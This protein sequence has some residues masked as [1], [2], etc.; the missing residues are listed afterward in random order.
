MSDFRS[1]ELK[2]NR[3]GD[4]RFV[5]RSVAEFAETTDIAALTHDGVPSLGLITTG[6]HYFDWH[7]TEAD[8]LDKVDP[9]DFRKCIAAL[10]VM[11][12]AL[13]DM[14]SRLAGTK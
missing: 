13:A 11:S 14:P 8:T 10:A 5:C 12:Y 7:H 1:Q 9:D 4:A 6:L 2:S 3:S